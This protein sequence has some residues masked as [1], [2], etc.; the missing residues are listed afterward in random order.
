MVDQQKVVFGVFDTEIEAERSVSA[1]LAANFSSSQI[2]VVMPGEASTLRVYDET[3]RGGGNTG[4]VTAFAG[5]G[6]LLGLLAGFAVVAIPGIGP[7]VAAGPF[8]GL[9]AGMAAG[10]TAGGLISAFGG[11]NLPD[12]ESIRYV[13]RI[14]EGRLLLSVHCESAAECERANTVLAQTGAQDMSTALSVV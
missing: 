11:F 4:A 10:G 9:L 12:E 2:S 13:G 3:S 7:L 5:A 8:L 6:G 14:K 1:L